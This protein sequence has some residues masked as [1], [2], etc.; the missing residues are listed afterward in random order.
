[1]DYYI[2]NIEKASVLLKITF[3]KKKKR[4]AFL[5]KSINFALEIYYLTFSISMREK[6]NFTVWLHHMAELLVP[7]ILMWLVI[8]FAV[9][10]IWLMF[11]HSNS[12][13]EAQALDTIFNAIVGVLSTFIVLGF[14]PRASKK[15]KEQFIFTDISTVALSSAICW[16]ILHITFSIA[17]GFLNHSFAFLSSVIFWGI[18]VIYYPIH[19]L[20]ARKTL[21]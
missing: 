9:P 19:Y 5:K 21:E 11:V 4:F 6:S 18:I 10:V 20:I 1:M 12:M 15:I 2:K 17:Q 7:A 3:A 8:M 14:I 13:Q 16:F